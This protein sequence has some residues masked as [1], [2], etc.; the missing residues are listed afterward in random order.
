M[1]FCLD[2]RLCEIVRS[3]GTGI[4]D[5]CELPCG[6]WEL[7]WGPLEK[8]PVLL[9]AEPSFQPCYEPIIAS[10]SLRDIP[11]PWL[12]RDVYCPIFFWQSCVISVK[13]P[14]TFGVYPVY[15]LR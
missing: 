11:H 13:I 15:S 4:T 14:D 5:C 12:F 10:L 7:N 6:C 3:P 2:E 8:Q 9:T 1:V